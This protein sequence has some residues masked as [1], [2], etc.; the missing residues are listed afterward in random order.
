MNDIMKRLTVVSTIFIPTYFSGRGIGGMNFKFMPE[1]DWRYGYVVAWAIMLVTGL[2]VYWF[3]K[4]KNG[5]NNY[6]IMKSIK[7]L[8]RIGTGPSSSHTMGPRRLPRFS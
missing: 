6:Y 2:L 1:L 3:L 4:G 7:E 8:Y 5:T